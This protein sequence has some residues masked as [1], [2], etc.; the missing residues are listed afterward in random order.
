MVFSDSNVLSRN[1][2]LGAL[3][4]DAVAHLERGLGLCRHTRKV[5]GTG[6][7]NAFRGYSFPRDAL[8]GNH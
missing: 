2:W 8:V 3:L 7:A 4:R 1:R 6:V 5:Q